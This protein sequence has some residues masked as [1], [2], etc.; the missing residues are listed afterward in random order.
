ME[1]EK[2]YDEENGGSGGNTDTFVASNNSAP[3]NPTNN[4]AENTS[5]MARELP[6]KEVE[7][8]VKPQLADAS[9]AARDAV[10][11]LVGPNAHAE[12]IAG[13][14]A[15]GGLKPANEI[16]V[17]TI[18]NTDANHVR[19]NQALAAQIFE[20]LKPMQH[21]A[22]QFSAS[23]QDFNLAGRQFSDEKREV[24]MAQNTTGNAVIIT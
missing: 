22:A 2:K 14:L 9:D 5:A 18:I 4:T 1:K 3:I 17:A 10:R 13:S 8:E 24:G 20:A 7:Q 11:R 16:A 21:L 19:E 12:A 6:S 23:M 15:V